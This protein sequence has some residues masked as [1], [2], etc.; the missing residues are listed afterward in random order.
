MLH[1]RGLAPAP[2]PRRRVSAASL[3]RAIQATSAYRGAVA[4][5]AKTMQT[6]QGT[7]AAL[8]AIEK[9]T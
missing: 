1:R 7:K 9:L 3:G 4:S 2:I 6:E 5:L 8:E